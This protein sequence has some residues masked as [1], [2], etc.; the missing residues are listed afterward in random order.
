MLLRLRSRLAAFW[1]L[2]ILSSFVGKLYAADPPSPEQLEFFERQVRP[3]LVQHCYACHAKGQKKGGL[4]LDSRAALLAGGDSGPAL[5]VDRLEASLLLEAVRYEGGV[6]MP[7]SGKLTAQEIDVLKR[8]VLQGAPWPPEKM[9]GGDIRESGT[10]DDSDRRFWSFVPPQRA[11]FP[12]V[13]DAA[14]SRTGIDPFIA[15]RREAEKLPVA[16][17]ADRRT[18]ARRLSLDLVGLPLSLEETEAFLADDGPDS[19]ARLVDRLLASPRHGERWARHWLDIARFGED[20]AHTFQARTYPEGY[21]YRDWIVSAFNG[22]LPYDQFVRRQIAGDLLRSA[23]DR[24]SLP[25]LGFFA[26][27]P[28]YY[29]DAGC[30]P[31]ALADEWDDR[32]DTLSRG[33]LGLTVACA[34]CHDHKFDPITMRDYYAL[35]GIFASSNYQELPLVPQADVDRF[36]AAQAAAKEQEKAVNELRQSL[37]RQ[38]AE[39]NVSLVARSLVASWT[40]VNRRKSDA[41]FPLAEAAQAEQL[42]EPLVDAWVKYLSGDQWPSKPL[43]APW[44]EFLASTDATHDLAGNEAIRAQAR[45]AAQ[46]VQD[47][48][49]TALARRRQLEREYEAARAAAADEAARKKVAK[50]PLEKEL[51]DLLKEWVEDAKS[52]LVPPK[53]KLEPHLDEARRAQLA[54]AQTEL[55]QRKK[56]VGPKY[57]FAHGL[58]EGEPKTL[59]IHLRGDH[60]KLGDEAPRRFLEVLSHDSPALV[61]AGSGRRELAEAIASPANPLTARVWV[62][63]VWQQHFGR[64]LVA[65]PSNFG[66]L[67]ARPTHPELLD[68]LAVRFMESGWSNKWLHR[69]LVLSRT[70]GLSAARSLEGQ[71][72]DPDNR[73]LWRASRRRLDIETW[74]DS[75]LVAADAID[76][77]LGGP[78]E[79]LASNNH[80]RRTLYSKVSRHE[81]NAML[82]LFDF[83][84]PNLTSEQRVITTVPL[85]QLFVL[86]SDFM[87]RLARGLA[88]RAEREGGADETQRLELAYQAAFGRRPSP[89]ELQLGR[90]FLAAASQPTVASPASA[91]AKPPSLPPLVQWCQALLAANELQFVD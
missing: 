70:Y 58:A 63:R 60:K 64:G 38:V 25:A 46:A 90:D 74:R 4:T 9:G 40:L 67:G 37:A 13:A 83:P 24:E 14:W 7:P 10:I 39:D 17:D 31:K 68:D 34:R 1:S 82:R 52:P 78:G 42:R 65:T 75:L 81:L 43:L 84:D 29:A 87:V 48:L 49:S 47:R 32:V 45:L 80:R 3:L 23:D 35:A 30:A 72:Q 56:Q 51:A 54:T 57:A 8:W 61:A 5:A 89:E 76:L 15:V 27:G 73:W 77:R 12:S 55:E 86:N 66:T 71:A 11:P 69:E 44:K 16:P 2:L 28:V 18:L 19:V 20:Q 26:L 36:N 21:R 79:D 88:S 85:Q 53:D 22:D 6:Q 41:R 59:K 62:N 91:N 50:P 33:F